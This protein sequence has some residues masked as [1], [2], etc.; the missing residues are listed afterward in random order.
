MENLPP[1]TAKTGG[2]PWPAEYLYKWSRKYRGTV[3]LILQKQILFTKIM[4][5]M[6]ILSK[7]VQMV[8]LFEAILIC[9]FRAA[10]IQLILIS[11]PWA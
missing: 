3:P 6:Y 5:T 2:A 11:N 4:S 7:R 9:I 8:A 10:C 1:V